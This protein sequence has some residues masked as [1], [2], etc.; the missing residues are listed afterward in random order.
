MPYCLSIQPYTLSNMKMLQTL[1]RISYHKSH[2]VKEQDHIIQNSKFSTEIVNRGK[3]INYQ[4]ISQK[5][6]K[7]NW[8][9]HAK[10][11]DQN[12]CFIMNGKTI[13]VDTV[14]KIN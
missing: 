4:Q 1:Y 7:I 9:S 6:S 8:N 3:S 12:Y 13:A 2:L 14:E 11:M 10:N 5:L